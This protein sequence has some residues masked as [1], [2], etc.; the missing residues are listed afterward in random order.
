MC[1]I[2]VLKE[3]RACGAMLGVAIGD[4]IG[5][6]FERASHTGEFRHDGS[7]F[8]WQ[9]SCGSYKNRYTKTVA[10]GT[11]SDDTQLTIAIGRCLLFADK[12]G[13][14]FSECELPAWL[15]YQQGGGKILKSVA[16][17]WKNKK[18]PWSSG[19]PDRYLDAG[20]NGAAMRI[21]P[22]VLYGASQGETS[23]D[24]VL[25]DVRRDACLTHGHPRAIV[26]ATCL[27]SLLYDLWNLPV[28]EQIPFG[29]LFD[30]AL[31]LQDH[32]GALPQVWPLNAWDCSEPLA[33]YHGK[34]YADC[35]QKTVDEMALYLKQ[36]KKYLV[37]RPMVSIQDFLKYIGA[38]G[39]QNGSGTSSVA[40]AILFAS[41]ESRPSI[42]AVLQSAYLRGVDTDTVASM[43]GALMGM[44]FGEEWFAE[45]PN[46]HQ[47]QDKAFLRELALALVRHEPERLCAQETAL[48]YPG[49]IAKMPMERES[50]EEPKGHQ[51][52][53]KAPWGQTFAIYTSRAAQKKGNAAE[54]SASTSI[55][56]PDM[57]NLFSKQKEQ[58]VSESVS[59]TFPQLD[60]RSLQQAMQYFLSKLQEDPSWKHKQIG[61][62]AKT[63]QNPDAQLTETMAETYTK[64]FSRTLP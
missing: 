59:A 8:D 64:F 49:D 52:Y 10:A 46:L 39:R 47:L 19:K 3:Q 61:T 32:W 4:A 34:T 42:D 20:A 36:C 31:N 21:L 5:W 60:Q 13:K 57:D 29:G 41:L 24:G 51:D 50:R 30:R 38:I 25:N 35:W 1:D 40:A 48:L 7:F 62:L 37:D 53:F 2:H 27:A 26:G 28:S 18:S 55:R 9:I 12:W 17:D 11:Y 58:A 43:T 6:P 22:H 54:Q 56:H 63:M 45:W 44:L 16:K 23:L 15:E 14:Q 33:I